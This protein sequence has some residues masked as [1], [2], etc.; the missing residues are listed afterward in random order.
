MTRAVDHAL[1]CPGCGSAVPRF[2]PFSDWLRKL[3]APLN[4]ATISNHNLDF[5]WHNYRENW[6]ITIEEKQYGGE[7]RF[8]QADTHGILRQMLERASNGVYQNARGRWVQIAYR[9]HYVVSFQQTTPNN[10]DYVCINDVMYARPYDDIQTVILHLLRFGKLPPSE[11]DAARAA[12]L[13]EL[14]V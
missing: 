12:Y 10:S 11:H 5:I 6:L 2:T 8:A 14:A 4:S 13:E 7:V 9:G 1:V 3:D